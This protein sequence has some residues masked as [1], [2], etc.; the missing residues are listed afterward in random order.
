VAALS[1][2][3]RPARFEK[4][5][6]EKGLDVRLSLRYPDHFVYGRSDVRRM[7][8]ILARRGLGTLVT[9]EK[10]WVKLRE[11]LPL[12]AELRLARVEIDIT[13]DDPVLECEKPQAS[14]A[15]SL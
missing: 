1:G 2:I 5:L 4:A 8:E 3:G 13:G 10:D 9:T 14:P 15:V 12:P 7:E 6:L 11:L